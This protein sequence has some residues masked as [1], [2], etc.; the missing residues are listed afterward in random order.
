MRDKAGRR[1]GR[2][3]VAEEQEWSDATEI[4]RCVVTTKSMRDRSTFAIIH[5][6]RTGSDAAEPRHM[7]I[8]LSIH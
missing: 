4:D 6:K 8:E 7:E 2:H 1:E 3:D 5:L